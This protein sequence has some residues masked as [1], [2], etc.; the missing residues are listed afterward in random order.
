MTWSEIISWLAAPVVIFGGSLLVVG[1]LIY[2]RKRII[3]IIVGS[4]SLLLFA[5]SAPSLKP[6]WPQAKR[7]ACLFN[8]KRIQE[9]KETFAK[10]NSK[11]EFYEPTEPEIAA[12]FKHGLPCCPIDNKPY[13]IGKIDGL[14][15]CPNAKLRGHVLLPPNESK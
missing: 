9:A 14:P 1:Y 7:N 12:F 3:A 6:A 11:N 8:M 2:R 15:A 5:I 4:L 13:V 10:A